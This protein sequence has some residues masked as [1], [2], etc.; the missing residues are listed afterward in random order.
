MYATLAPIAAS[1]SPDGCFDSNALSSRSARAS[2]AL[3]PPTSQS[4]PRTA[5]PRLP[6]PYSSVTSTRRQRWRIQDL[7]GVNG[8]A[9]RPARCSITRHG[10]LRTAFAFTRHPPL[11]IMRLTITRPACVLQPSQDDDHDETAHAPSEGNG[12][13]AACVYAARL[14]PLHP[15]G[16]RRTGSKTS[17]IGGPI[18]PLR[19][20]SR[21]CSVVSTRA[22]ICRQPRYCLPSLGFANEDQS[23][24]SP[25]STKHQHGAHI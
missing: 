9:G 24:Q 6:S 2:S 18:L 25:K 12:H 23:S 19:A 22:Q 8:I 14:R 11:R 5:L 3:R 7:A 1:I 4:L 10:R 17:R 20:H 21:C 16:H 15:A 13:Q